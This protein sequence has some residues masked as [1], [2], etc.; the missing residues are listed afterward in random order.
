[1]G[2]HG[3]WEQIAATGIFVAAYF[4]IA[5]DKI[6]KTTVALTGAMIVVV[7]GVLSQEEAFGEAAAL[8]HVGVDWN[9]IFLLVGMMIIVN[10]I[11]PTGMFHWLGVRCAKLVRCRPVPLIITLSAATAFLSAFLDNVTTVLLIAPVTIYIARDLHIDPVPILICEVIASNIGGTATLI[12]DP[13][14]ILIGSYAGLTF[15]DFASNLTL[16]VIISLAAFVLTIRAFVGRRMKVDPEHVQRVMEM[17]ERELLTDRKALYKGV[18]VLGLTI[19]GFLVHHLLGLHPATIA[20]SGATLLLLISG[21]GPRKYLEEIEWSTIFFFLGLF[22]MVGSLVKVGTIEAMADFIL[23]KTGGS[24]PSLSMIILWFSAAA[25]GFVDNIP[26]TAIMCPMIGDIAQ[27]I[28]RV[29]AEA[30][31]RHPEIQVLW[32]SLALGACLGGN[33]TI[34]GASANVVVAGTSEKHGY[35]I[36]FARFFKYGALFTVES[37]VISA[38]YIWLRYLR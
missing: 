26:Y 12:G 32:W 13:P 16:P 24:I 23:A 17:D 29:P 34:I 8:P 7:L 27:A 38:G 19:C 5:L 36:S 20:M 3:N 9:V 22:I 33:L 4:L 30:A 14:N 31:V 35:K 11:R 15:T 25:S 37:L 18:A 28:T 21:H 6:H 10:V 1:M 2:T